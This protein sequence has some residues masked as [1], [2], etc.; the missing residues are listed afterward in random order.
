MTKATRQEWHNEGSFRTLSFVTNSDACNTIRMNFNLVYGIQAKICG[1]R[2]TACK[3][4]WRRA[5]IL[6]LPSW[7]VTSLTLSG[8]WCHSFISWK[9]KAIIV[10][11]T[12]YNKEWN[13]I[14]WIFLWSVMQQ[15]DK[16]KLFALSYF[17]RRT[18]NVCDWICK[19]NFLLLLSTISFRL[20]RISLFLKTFSC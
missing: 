7:G 6:H 2:C 14:C 20:S 19:N 10:S 11:S 5:K 17:C 16:Q 3:T 8:I 12:S 4:P 15:T 13:K 18:K 9:F 1:M